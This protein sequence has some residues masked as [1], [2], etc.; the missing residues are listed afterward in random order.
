MN[1]KK[2]AVTGAL[3]ISLLTHVTAQSLGC[4]GAVNLNILPQFTGGY[5]PM[6]ATISYG[7]VNT[8]T[9][10]YW[11]GYFKVCTG[12]SLDIQG[13]SMNSG[14]DISMVAW[15]PFTS[16][17][18]ICSNLTTPNIAGCAATTSPWEQIALGAVTTG[19]YYMV[20]IASDSMN[21]TNTI[22]FVGTAVVDISCWNPPG[23]FPSAG[24]ESP[25]LVT[26]DSLTQEYKITW[27]QLPPNPVDYYG[28]TR[29]DAFGNHIVIDTVH[30]TSLSEY[31]DYS[32]DPNVHLEEYGI[33][34]YDTCATFWTDNQVVRP[35]FCQS[36][37]STQNTVN[38]SWTSYV[39]TNNNSAAYYVIY[40]GP[41]FSN[42]T[43][44]DTVGTFINNYTD[45]NPLVGTS[46]YKIGVGL[47]APCI[48]SRMNAVAVQSYSNAAPITV[49]G[50][51]EN[52]FAHVSLFPNPTDGA[53]RVSGVNQS[54]LLSVIDVTGR[55]V[56]EQSIGASPSQQIELGFLESGMYSVT[57]QNESSY[58]RTMI[59]IQH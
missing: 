46:Y 22:N 14:D 5:S 51:N 4:S 29:T 57:L 20:C 9:Q 10:Y 38:V 39:S 15:G 45:I 58:F 54:C 41:S 17:T 53:V 2:L 42:M 47:S 28:I 18:N 25:C 49:V 19:D 50:I 27:E 21:A 6:N 13:Y 1:M 32:A 35:V 3:L 59:S 8:A 24:Y 40:R 11:Y 16:T 52:S 31:I 7:C 33:I 23:C 30:A 37:L 43:V 44:L 48:P 26:V 55:V 36:S 34:T 56:F 12:G